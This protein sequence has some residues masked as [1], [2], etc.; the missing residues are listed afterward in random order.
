LS[1]TANQTSNEQVTATENETENET[2]TVSACLTYAEWVKTAQVVEHFSWSTHDRGVYQIDHHFICETTSWKGAYYYTSHC[3][4]FGEG[5]DA[6][7]RY[8]GASLEN[9]YDP[10]GYGTPFFNTLEEAFN[11][12]NYYAA[13]RKLLGGLEEEDLT[14]NPETGVW[15]LAEQK[16]L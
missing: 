11:F 5:T 4:P 1:N 7:L 6:H 16:K 3:L 10:D 14:R 2:K 13:N 15:E 12:C 9:I 8:F